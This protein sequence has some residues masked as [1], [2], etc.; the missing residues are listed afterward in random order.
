MTTFACGGVRARAGEATLRLAGP[1]AE[2]TLRVGLPP[3]VARRIPAPLLDLLE[4]SAYAL[5]AEAF[6]GAVAPP[7]LPLRVPVRASQAFSRATAARALVRATTVLGLPV[8]IEAVAGRRPL[9]PT[10][11][12][13]DADPVLAQIPPDAPVDVVLFSAGLDSLVGALD[14]VARGGFVV[15]LHHRTGPRLPARVQA[16]AAAVAGRGA[17]GRVAFVSVWA[18]GPRRGRQ[19][20]LRA[21]LYAAAAGAVASAFGPGSA[22]RFFENGVVSLGLPLSA[23]GIGRPSRSTHPRALVAFARLLEALLP[24]AARRPIPVD[25]AFLFSTKGEVAARLVP[26]EAT[27]L[28]AETRSCTGASAGHCGVCEACVDRRFAVLA[29]GLA[30]HDPVEGY[31]VELL[32]GARDTPHAR[33]AAIA[34]VRAAMVTSDEDEA[35]FFARHGDLARGLSAIPGP[36]AD[37]AERLFDLH[38]RHAKEIERVLDEGFHAHAAA[39]RR[40]ILPETSL[41]VLALPE[42][43]LRPVSPRAPRP[44]RGPTLRIL[45]LSDFHFSARRA[46]DQDPTLAG[47]V[48]RVESFAR[49]GLAPDLVVVT[50]DVADRGVAAEYALAEAFFAQRL[51]PAAKL[52]AARLYFVPGNHDVDRGA[53]GEVAQAAQASLLQKESQDALAAV[54]GNPRE[55]AVLLARHDAYLDFVGRVRGLR[56]ELPWWKERLEVGGLSLHLAGLCS[57]WMACSDADKGR[58]LVA[59]YQL[60]DALAGADQ[61]DVAIA[62][63][64]HPWDYLADFD[65]HEAREAVQRRCTVTLRGHLHSVDAAARVRPHDHHVELAAGA[66]YGGSR[67]PH[68]FSLVEIEPSARALRLRACVWDGHAFILDRNVLGGS[69]DGVAT[70]PLGAPRRGAS[71]RPAS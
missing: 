7:V 55:R 5:A 65:A 30:A 26:H 52:P 60:H 69:S 9:G 6:V 57:S 29:A 34:Y 37:V 18:A 23:V 17:P 27:A 16:L 35:T 15:L 11:A 22:V 14:T 62:L 24:P 50:G 38:R 10:A 47:L 31:G 21:L 1:D 20:R 42:S 59:R 68:G 64:H 41:L 2:V 70:L 53:V 39:L 3:D 13:E 45:H 32:A 25:N 12:L 8:A 19:P 71:G 54:L 58:L 33:S 43:Y 56:P 44:Q 46:W 4:V 28:L 48:A 36:T 66:S 67:H 51:L 49:E 40:G 61:T 63:L